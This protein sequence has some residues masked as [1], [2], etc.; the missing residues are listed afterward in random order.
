MNQ[1][2]KAVSSILGI[3][4]AYLAN[5]MHEA[6]KTTVQLIEKT[7]NEQLKAEVMTRSSTES[8]TSLAIAAN[9]FELELKKI[10]I[11]KMESNKPPTPNRDWNKTLP[12]DH[13]P[14]QPWLSKLSRE[15]NPR[16][17][18][19]ELTDTP[20][21]FS[22]FVMNRLNVETLTP[23]LL[24]GPTFKL[25]KGTCKS[26]VELEYFFE[27][28]YKT[29]TEQINW[30][31]PEGQQYPHDLRKPL[32]VIP[33]SCSRQ[34][35]P[36]D[37]FINNDLAYLCGGVSSRT[38]ATSVT[39]TK[40]AD[41][42]HIKWIK[43]LVPNAMWRNMLVMYI[44]D[45]ESSLSQS[46]RL[47]NGMATNI[48]IGSPFEKMMTSF[49][50]LMKNRDKKNKLIRVDELHKFSDGTLKYV[51]AALEDRLKGIRMEY[52]PQ[53]I[54]RQSDRER[55]KAM[56]QAI[57][58]HLKSRRIMRSLERFVGGR[59][60]EE[61]AEFDESNAN[62]LER[63]Y[64]SA[65]NPVKE[66]LLKL[67]LPDHRIH[68]DGGEDESLKLFKSTNHERYEHVGLEVTSLQDGKVNKMAK[69]D[70]AWLMISRCSIS[71]SRQ[72]KEQAQDLKSMITTSNHKLMI[73]VKRAQD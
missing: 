24:A 37:H 1:F 64:T 51:Q 17:S 9:L 22:V 44:P 70:Y 47:S 27:E 43:E 30:H 19:D 71:H 33:N 52:L 59:P 50:H 62:V 38:Y 60:Y 4:D 63:F 67:N 49:T 41:Y 18:F 20:F 55:A 13:G 23:K 42:S 36:F 72:A 65:G 26:L 58:K 7:V 73:E 21:D 11:E 48:W 6:I 39:K 32:P 53:T 61:H 68:K 25:M 45:V 8:K 12:A 29:T 16:D 57:D 69:R 28:V 5:K 40:D 2:A 46:F 14:V 66:I 56:I 10:L 31:N 3:L 54:Y 34:V 15:E 35:I